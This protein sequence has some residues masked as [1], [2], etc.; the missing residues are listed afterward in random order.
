MKPK[1][2]S[3]Q[4]ICDRKAEFLNALSDK[5]QARFSQ[6]KPK[7]RAH[8][9][10][11]GRIAIKLLLQSKTGRSLKSIEISTDEQGRPYFGPWYLSIS[12]S[13]GIAGAVADRQPV[14]LDLELIKHRPDMEKI[15]FSKQERDA[16]TQLPSEVRAYRSTQRWTELEAIAKYKGTGLRASFS[17]LTQPDDTKMKH[18]KLKIDSKTLCW[19][20]VQSKSSDI[21]K[22][23][24]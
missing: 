4:E 11:A 5:E 22:E 8:E 9:W 14:G 3:V 19:T 2:I 24:N 20:L 23:L 7:R 6:I 15:A 12:H 10:L 21:Q 1:F 17:S 16:W 13:N 18:G